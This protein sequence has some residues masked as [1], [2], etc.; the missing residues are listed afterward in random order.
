MVSLFPI[1]F[2][3]CSKQN[4]NNF[5]TRKTNIINV[6]M[7]YAEYFTK[8]TDYSSGFDMR[9]KHDSIVSEQEKKELEKISIN[10]KKQNLL[11]LLENTDISIF[12]KNDLIEKYN[13]LNENYDANVFNGGLLNDWEFNI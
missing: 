1:F 8:T 2:L 4:N 13:I 12:E 9:F 6:D 10:F 7:N 3:L 5:Y 11:F